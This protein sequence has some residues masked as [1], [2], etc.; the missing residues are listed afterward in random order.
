MTNDKEGF[1]KTVA[2]SRIHAEYTDPDKDFSFY[3]VL[4]KLERIHS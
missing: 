2:E 3:L 1:E 4:Q